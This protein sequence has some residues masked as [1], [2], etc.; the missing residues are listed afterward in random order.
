MFALSDRPHIN[1][2]NFVNM[3]FRFKL[4]LHRTVKVQLEGMRLYRTQMY[5]SYNLYLNDILMYTWTHA[6]S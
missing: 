5:Q 1:E 6:Y 4:A 3:K 2:M